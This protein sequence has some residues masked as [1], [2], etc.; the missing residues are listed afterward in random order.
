MDAVQKRFGERIRKLRAAKGLSQEAFAAKAGLHRTYVGGAERG[1]RNVSL[2]NI[3]RIANTLQI[4][5]S[6]L[7]KGVC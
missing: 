6:E 1:E 4:T 2:Q 7:L 5:G 3:A